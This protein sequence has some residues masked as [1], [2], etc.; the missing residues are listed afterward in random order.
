M[1]ADIISIP[2][3][4]HKCKMPAATKLKND[5]GSAKV[6]VHLPDTIAACSDCGKYWYVNGGS[7][8]WHPV[9]WYHFDLKRRIRDAR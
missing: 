9:S 8:L 3:T 5:W 2:P 4:A 6:W 7:Q 1:G